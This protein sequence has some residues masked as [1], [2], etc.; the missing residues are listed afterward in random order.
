MH[1][2]LVPASVHRLYPPPFCKAGLLCCKGRPRVNLEG[3]LT[4][5]LTAGDRSARCLWQ[6]AAKLWADVH[7]RQA[8]RIPTCFWQQLADKCLLKC[9]ACE[10]IVAVQHATASG[11][12]SVC[13]G[14]CVSGPACFGAIELRNAHSGRSFKAVGKT[15]PNSEGLNSHDE[16]N[17][18][19][20]CPRCR[21][22]VRRFR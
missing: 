21:R 20:R 7:E 22:A 12:A 11:L 4:V 14:V 6:D 2:D 17:D 1:R 16:T 9:C 5:R 15:A 3:F 18:R 19:G 10:T 8:V 13:P